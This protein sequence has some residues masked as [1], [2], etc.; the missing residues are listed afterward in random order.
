MTRTS[1]LIASFI[2]FISCE[3]PTDIHDV[4]IIGGGLMGSSTA[5]ELSKSGEKILLIEQQDS[6]YTSGSS[7][8]EARIS[9]SLGVK[10]DI[11][12]FLQQKS[13]AGTREL[14][15][16]LNESEN[17]QQHSMDD[18][19]RTSPITY[20]RYKSQDED[21]KLLLKDQ[22]DRYEFAPDRETAK[23]LFGMEIPDSLMII[24]EYKQ[25]SGTLNPKVLISKLHLGISYAGSNILYNEK[26]IS[27]KKKNALYEIQIENTKTGQLKTML[28]K[29]IV[30]AA[31]PYNGE[32]IKDV[33]PYFKELIMPKRLFLAFL[34]IDPTIYNNLSSEQQERLQKSYPVADIS[35]EI[36]YSMIENYDEDGQPILKVGGHFL[37]TEIDN[38]DEVWER[39]LT[40]D[41]INWSKTNTI[42][43]LKLLDLPVMIDDLVFVSGYSCVYS[44]T[45]SEVPYV[46]NVVGQN[47]EIDQNIV[48][49]GGM[50]GIGAKGSLTYG[51]I[52]SNLLM[53]KDDTTRMY[54]KTKAALGV[55]RLVEDI[56]A[57]NKGA[58]KPLASPN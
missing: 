33:A 23:K 35:P 15:E 28:S 46:T 13:I 17:S 18:I 29:K 5:W 6:I 21:V 43:Y 51:L 3:S 32:L 8:G 12:S 2:V 14:I 57:R 39:E 19:Y 27:L 49:V 16:Y 55:Q 4:V 38:L 36:Y 54:Q 44:L 56:N 45:D 53:S 11:F 42:R 34:K 25:Y 37:R 24:R 47:N 48:L 22:E 9:R 58:I 41:E 31:G 52:A 40:Q 1:I 50:S 20:I 10:D 7:Y 30:A 26:V